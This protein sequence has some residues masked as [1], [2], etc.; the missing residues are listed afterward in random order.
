MTIREC[1]FYDT[2]ALE[3]RKTRLRHFANCTVWTAF[4]GGKHFIL[5]DERS[6]H[7]TTICEYDSQE[8]FDEDVAYLTDLDLAG[9]PPG[10]R[11]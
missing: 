7:H 8:E 4:Q 6:R 3:L 11:D 10:E 2:V 5:L 9:L 1:Y